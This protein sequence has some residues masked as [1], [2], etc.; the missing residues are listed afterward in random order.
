MSLK[1]TISLQSLQVNSLPFTQECL[2]CQLSSKGIN[3]QMN[4]NSSIK[5]KIIGYD[6]QPK[7]ET[8]FNISSFNAS[9]PAE[10]LRMSNSQR[11][12]RKCFRVICCNLNSKEKQPCEFSC[13]YCFLSHAV[14]ASCEIQ[15]VQERNLSNQIIIQY[16]LYNCSI[17][18]EVLV[19]KSFGGQCNII[20]LQSHSN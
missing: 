9:Q 10:P 19:I 18:A 5:N 6:M 4:P 14:L 13:T 8:S 12:G 1:Y 7:T 15:T 20:T 16:K 17:I 2:S 3:H 11:Q